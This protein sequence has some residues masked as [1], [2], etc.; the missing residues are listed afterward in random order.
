MHNSLCDRNLRPAVIH[1]LN[2]LNEIL[3]WQAQKILT[4]LPFMACSL[5]RN[6]LSLVL[7][8][9]LH[10]EVFCTETAMNRSLSSCATCPS[11][12]L[13]WSEVSL[14]IWQSPWW[15]R[16]PRPASW[17]SA[18]PLGG[19][20]VAGGPALRGGAPLGRAV[21]SLPSETPSSHRSVWTLVGPGAADA[22]EWSALSWGEKSRIHFPPKT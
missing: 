5:N 3:L 21:E 8:A 20:S 1:G 10:H 4:R 12:S 7:L 15:S 9:S 13:C 18:A 14:W 22:P 11:S 6:H 16:P 17:R 2:L 19:P